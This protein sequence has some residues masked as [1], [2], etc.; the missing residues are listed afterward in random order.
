MKV[1]EKYRHIG[2]SYPGV[3]RGWV[4]IVEKAI[5]EIESQM[6]PKWIPMFVKRKIH[7]W[8]TGNSVVQVENKIWYR[9]RQKLT[10]GQ[11][12][13]DIKDKYATLRIYGFFGEEIRKIIKEATKEC[14]ETCES[15]G[16]KN[17]VKT[18]GKGWIYN[19]CRS[20]RNKKISKNK[21][22]G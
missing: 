21:N 16:S 6:W 18:T 19:L 20:C 12:I 9:I 13:T 11:I 8:G 15:C 4:P 2:Y 17:G 7:L 3:P 22:N 1:S 10:K 14:S 5:I